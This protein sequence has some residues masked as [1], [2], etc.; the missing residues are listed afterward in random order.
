MGNGTHCLLDATNVGYTNPKGDTHNQVFYKYFHCPDISYIH[1]LSCPNKKLTACFCDTYEFTLFD[2]FLC[3]FR[4]VQAIASAQIGVAVLAIILNI[5]VLNAYIRRKKL[6]NK[7]G[8]TLLATQA[9]IDLFNTAV[10]ATTHGSAILILPGIYTRLNG[11]NER[12]IILANWF[13][14]FLSFYSSLGLFTLIATERYLSLSKPLWHRQ[15]VTKSWILKR[16]ILVLTMTIVLTPLLAYSATNNYLSLICVLIIIS[17]VVMAA[18]SILLTLSF[19]KARKS[20]QKKQKRQLD[21]ANTMNPIDREA[22]VK[23]SD[24]TLPYIDRKVLRLTLIFLVMYIVFL[25]ALVPLSVSAVLWAVRGQLSATPALA[26][27]LC[28]C[29]T[30]LVNPILTLSMRRDFGFRNTIRE[31]ISRKMTKITVISNRSSGDTPELG[32]RT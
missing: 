31:S 30:S 27:T 24:I 26:G 18:V 19:L 7:V 10:V 23:K 6:Q 15:Y 9:V 14:W 12:T 2:A 21:R 28:F 8:N 16:L 32:S 22:N 3:S 25:T 4:E 1:S 5:L 20:L 29:T 17:F 13:L 11:K